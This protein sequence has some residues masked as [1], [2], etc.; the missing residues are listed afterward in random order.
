[1][2]KIVK[3]ENKYKEEVIN[4]LIKIAVDEF[5]HY[6]WIDYLKNK[7]FSPYLL[8][9][10]KFLIAIKD[11]EIIGTIGGLK[12][13]NKII[14]LN[15]FYVKDKYRHQGIGKKL[16][17]LLLCFCKEKQYETIILCTYDE[18][19]I[20]KKIYDKEN[21]ILY[22]EDGNERWMKKEI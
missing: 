12:V 21:F 11:N 9:D 20:A 5:K 18:Y 10:S 13:N 15:S 6:N 2:Y 19:D 7:D 3:Y 14:K 8:D 1:M 17:R 4:F 16:Y 22:K